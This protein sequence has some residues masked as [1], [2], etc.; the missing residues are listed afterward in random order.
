[1]TIFNNELK[2]IKRSTLIWASILAVLIIMMLPVYIR[3]V[4]GGGLPL[5]NIS[6]NAFFESMGTSMEILVTPIGMYSFLTFFILFATSMYGMNL[7]L[8]MMTK[9]YRQSSADFLMTKPYS[10]TMIYFSK[11]M[12]AATSIVTIGLFYMAASLIAMRRSVE[13]GFS[14]RSVALI[15]L[16]IILVPLMMLF[17]GMLVGTVFS[18]LRTTIILSTGVIFLSYANGSVSRIAG[19]GALRYLSPLHYFNA[20][21]VI[22]DNVY[23]T[24]FVLVF[25]VSCLV[26]VFLGLRIFQK[27]DIATVS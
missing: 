21:S 12:A 17:L 26:L 19:I 25:I 5:D 8:G 9:E 3:M 10:R 18:R 1:M 20:A 16:P 24:R 7:G 11:V 4:S 23:E 6:D 27:K 13:T 15:A 14:M 2:Q 22:V